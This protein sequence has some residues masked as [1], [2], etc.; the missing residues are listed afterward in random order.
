MV[1]YYSIVNF[2]L[3]NFYGFPSYSGGLSTLILGFYKEAAAGA[4]RAGVVTAA[5]RADVAIDKSE[6]KAVTS[7]RNE[8]TSY[9]D[10]SA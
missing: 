10:Y 9:A 3:E 4:V 7:A 1:K 5:A 8:P 2:Q 6:R